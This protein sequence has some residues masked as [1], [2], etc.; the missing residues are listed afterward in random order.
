MK[1][2]LQL[3]IIILFILVTFFGIGPILMADGS[4]EE[5][6]ITLGI[7]ILIYMFLIWLFRFISNRETRS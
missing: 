3:G 2:L 5:R 6:L 1:K 4:I 7:V